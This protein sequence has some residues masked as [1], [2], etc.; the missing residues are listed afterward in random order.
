M[1]GEIVIR[2]PAYVTRHQ[3]EIICDAFR[4]GDKASVF[5]DAETAR[6]MP[7]PASELNGTNRG[8]R[9]AVKG[10]MLDW[11]YWGRDEGLCKT[12]IGNVEK[13]YIIGATLRIVGPAYP[14]NV[15]FPIE[16]WPE[17]LFPEL[18]LDADG[19]RTIAE[20]ISYAWRAK[21]AYNGCVLY[22]D[23]K[24]R[25]LASGKAAAIEMR[26]ENTP[27]G[28]GDINIRHIGRRIPDSYYLITGA[29]R[30]IYTDDGAL[31]IS[32]WIGSEPREY[33]IRTVGKV[34][35]MDRRSASCA[36]KVQAS[37]HPVPAPRQTKLEAWI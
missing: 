8:C 14:G 17:D 18:V 20:S 35:E 3:A 2:E 11:D 24:G 25:H 37:E 22:F 36:Y 32:G 5:F 31:V 6:P 30:Q 10:A 15:Q 29:Y 26:I 4:R 13:A 12:L 9:L 28:A 23:A 34:P 16:E 21:E 33:R 27:Y 1:G 7:R 19:V